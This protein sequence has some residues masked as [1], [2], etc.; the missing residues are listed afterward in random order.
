MTGSAT[1]NRRLLCIAFGVGAALAV[2]L[3]S[4]C[5]RD[6]SQGRQ[7]IVLGFDGMDPVLCE[8]LMNAGRL[9][10]IARLR[11]AGGFKPL[12]TSTPPQSPV[13]WCTL[14]TGTNPGQHGIFDFLHRDP[15]TY[16]AYSS[17]AETRRIAHW[18]DALLP[19]SIPLGDYKF[20]LV[21][22]EVVNLRHGKPFWEYLTEAGIPT[23]VYRI[24]ANYPP[25]PSQG[26][27]FL[28]LSDMGT[29]DIR[30]TAGTFSYYTD[31]PFPKTISG[32][33]EDYSVH[34][35][36]DKAE[37][38]FRGPYDT[39]RRPELGRDGKP[40]PPNPV[41][42]PFTI[43]RD[44]A[45]PTIRLVWD[46]EQVVLR[47]GEWSDW[48]PIEFKLGP[49]W[50]FSD[51]PILP[52]AKSIGRFYLQQVR[53]EFQLYVSPLNIDPLDPSLPIS[54][55][56]DFATEVAGAVGRYY[57]QGLPESTKALIH[58][59]L[60][61]EEFL[62]Q[63]D[64]VTAERFKLFEFAL[65]HFKTGFL[66]FYFGGTDQVAHM[67]WG[68]R[69]EHHPGLTDE[70]IQQYK[71]SIGQLY[72]RMDVTIGQVMQ[73]FPNATVMLLSD[74][75]FDV[76][77]R[78]FNPN[79]WLLENGYTVQR[80]TKL[81]AGT[82]LNFDF[83]K[84]KAYALG[85]NGLYI[86]L[87]GRER[88]GIVPA[89]EKQQLLDEIARKLLEYRDPQTGLPVIKEVYQAQRV[90]SGPQVAIGPDIQIGYHRGFRAS[91][92]AALTG[93]DQAV[94]TDNTDAWNGDHCI[95]TD[96]V[97][98]VLLASQPI[99]AEGPSLLDIAPSIL[100]WFGLEV[101]PQME[102][103]SVFDVGAAMSSRD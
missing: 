83:A 44:P 18:Y 12:G 62:D 49:R 103:R 78:Q 75:G 2:R 17:T 33:G 61:R 77:E 76:F 98:G 50:P 85:I 97:P 29:P 9:P 72:E 30:G 73:R 22:S 23:H 84:T 47:Q 20:D 14:I 67:F 59:V 10:N 64:L 4:G 60:N 48:Y 1:V 55:P 40:K 45:E 25:T 71:D 7:L 36:N 35:M 92:T 24:P 69:G 34:F 88:L 70:Q 81:P 95:A 43:Y 38:A 41:E 32:G 19:E 31:N 58:G 65:D 5:D 89:A 63:A 39:M 37:G 56:D 82:P 28:C 52:P 13:A 100:A 57:S 54:Q 6:R 101:P 42:T 46:D 87:Q 91:W 21:S 66:F 99:P 90:Y 96:L 93:F 86:N 102:G 8:E 53:P 16:L 11:D 79:N 68:A 94:M 3:S 15:N 27:E 26:A 51:T 80:N 74:H